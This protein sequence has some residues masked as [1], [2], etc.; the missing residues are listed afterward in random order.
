MKLWPVVLYTLVVGI[1][2]IFIPHPAVVV[3]AG[4]APVIIIQVFKFPF[5]VILGFIIFSFFRIHEVFPVLGPLRIPS[6]LALGS[7]AVLGWHLFVTKEIEIY[8]CRQLTW[9]AVFFS[10][11]VFG[12]IFATNRGGAIA[13]FSATYVKIGIMT[14]AIAWLSRLPKNFLLASRLFS[15]SGILVAIVAMKNKAAG[16]GLVEGTRVT[17]GRD[18]GSVLGDPNDL[19]LVLLFPGSFTL[20]LAL[21]KGLGKFERFLACAGFL[22]IIS[23]IIATQSR[24]GLLGIMTI[25]GLFAWNHFKSKLLLIG[26]ASILA[27]ILLVV[28]GIADRKSGGAHEE[29]I[30]ESSMGRLYAW[31]AAFH[32]AVANPL[33]GVGLANFYDNYYFYSSHWDGMNHAV[34]STWM[35]VTAETGFLGLGVFITILVTTVGGLRKTMRY[36]N[37]MLDKPGPN[38]QTLHHIVKPYTYA[39]MAGFA[40]FCIS[41]TFLTQGFT[42]PVYILIALSVGLIK[43]VDGQREHWGIPEEVKPRRY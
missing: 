6:L 11:V 12:I 2:W 32:M 36:I 27:P 9:L 21:A 23:G 18:I 19:S 30:D 35:G 25:S 10:L 16:I 29:G 13:Y 8:W 31:E 33:T 3:A 40:S 34:H 1:A 14:L 39:L 41:G 38:G 4:I 17:I 37:K 24:G 43:Y 26:G 20:S 5:L 7:L 42:W 22:T 28:A 15:L